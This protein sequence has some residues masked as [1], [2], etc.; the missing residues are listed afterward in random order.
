MKTDFEIIID[1]HVPPTVLQLCQSIC[2]TNDT[3]CRIMDLASYSRETI[4]NFSYP[5][6]A[7]ID[8]EQFEINIINNFLMR[9]INGETFT[10]WQLALYNKLNEIMP[11]YNMLFEALDGWDLFNSGEVTNRT[12]TQENQSEASN[13]SKSTGTNTSDRRY[14]AMPDNQLDEVRNGKYITDYNYDT[15]IAENNDSSNSQGKSTSNNI[16]RIERTP[17]DK[18]SIYNEF[19]QEKNNIMSKIYKDLDVCFYGIYDL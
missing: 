1:N 2:Y 3:P 18:I 6:T 7:K 10:S 9:R 16:E 4:F 8:K 15:N 5:I 12:L 14:S 17:A 19:I 11:K 13:E